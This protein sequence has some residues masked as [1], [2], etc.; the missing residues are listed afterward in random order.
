MKKTPAATHSP[1]AAPDP[2]PLQKALSDLDKLHAGIAD[3]KQD[4]VKYQAFYDGLIAHGDPND[5]DVVR[6]AANA[7]TRLEMWPNYIRR[8]EENI[9]PALDGLLATTRAFDKALVL[10]GRTEYRA[11]IVKIG[12]K[13][14]AALAAVVVEYHIDAI[15]AAGGVAAL[16]PG[17]RHNPQNHTAFQTG[18]D[19]N[20]IDGLEHPTC[21][22]RPDRYADG[23]RELPIS[24]ARREQFERVL[25]RR[26]AALLKVYEIWKERGESFV[27]A[28]LTQESAFP[29]TEAAT[30]DSVRPLPKAPASNGIMG[31]YSPP[32]RGARAAA[33]SL[34][35]YSR[36]R[37]P[38]RDPD[39][40]PTTSAP[41]ADVP[42][43]QPRELD[44]ITEAV[45]LRARVL[46]AGAGESG[47]LGG[48]SGGPSRQLTPQ[49]DTPTSQPP[50]T[51]S[52][53]PAVDLQG[54]NL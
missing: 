17:L 18:A 20:Y 49:T 39:H 5:P 3:M 41:P 6:D 21:F 12:A 35:G 36:T 54:M 7:K 11:Q 10:A 26:A 34:G 40:P 16:Y 1:T 9:F 53:A 27:P 4:V 30:T 14:E 28:D 24:V 48:R 31:G 52:G 15:Q 13:V 22:Q 42:L 2:R 46:E 51:A 47:N 44:G 37:L 23:A 45:G 29:V 50:S 8:N 25:R 33:S 19:Q 32:D 43:A 38:D